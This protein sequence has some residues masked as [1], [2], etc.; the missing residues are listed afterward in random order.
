MAKAAEAQ[1]IQ[2]RHKTPGAGAA[3]Q[4]S[5]GDSDGPTRVS[6][7]TQ[8][9]PKELIVDSPHSWHEGTLGRGVC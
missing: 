2:V 4:L 1:M 5:I 6:I 9:L 7:S 3:I 8:Y